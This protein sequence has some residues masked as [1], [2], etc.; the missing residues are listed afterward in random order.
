M[1]PIKCRA[2]GVE[3]P[4]ARLEAIPGVQT[5]VQ[6]SDAKAYVGYPV[7]M[8]GKTCSDVVIHRGGDEEA[9]R[10]MR[11]AYRRER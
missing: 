4:E 2:C 6:H 7:Q 11:R 9:I 8:A 3:I 10:Q 1:G 5:C